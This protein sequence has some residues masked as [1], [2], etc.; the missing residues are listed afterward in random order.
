[1]AAARRA[2]ADIARRALISY[3][4]LVGETPAE[5]GRRAGAARVAALAARSGDWTE[6]AAWYARAVDELRGAPSAMLLGRLADAEWRAGRADAARAALAR[7]LEIA[8]TNR[9]L[10][11]LQRRIR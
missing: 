10:L 4:T 5:V 7:A 2:H 8:P 9:T 6:A 3:R 11:A 1:V